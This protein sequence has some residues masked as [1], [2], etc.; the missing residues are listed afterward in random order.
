MIM[1]SVA[2]SEM[3]IYACIFAVAIHFC[4]T[5]PDMG[6]GEFA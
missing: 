2:V 5:L 1:P 6:Q 3:N 4:I